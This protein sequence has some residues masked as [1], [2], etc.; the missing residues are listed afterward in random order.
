MIFWITNNLAHVVQER[1]SFDLFLYLPG[2]A[3]TLTF[4]S[5]SVRTLF[6]AMVDTYIIRLDPSALRPALKSIILALVPGL[7]DETSDDFETT[8][9]IV[10]KLQ[11]ITY[12][13]N[14]AKTDYGTPYFWQ[15]LFL[16]SIT[17]PSRRLGILAYLN[18]YL[19]KLGGPDP[20][21]S[22]PADDIDVVE[23]NYLI[24][25]VTKPDPGLL[26]RCFSTGLNDEQ[27]LVQR[28][29]LDLLVTHIP[30]HSPLLQRRISS[31]DFR[32]LVAAATSVVIRRDMSLNRRLWSWFLGP[33]SPG[34]AGDRGNITSAAGSATDFGQ[35][36]YFE[37]FGLKPLVQSLQNMIWRNSM[38][39]PERAKPFRICLSLMDRWEVGS[40]IVPRVFLPTMRS[41]QQYDRSAPTRAQFD[42]VFRSASSFFDG[43][44]SSLIFSEIIGLIRID[45]SEVKPK[46]QSALDDL[47]L[48]SFIVANFKTREEEMLL[49]H[50]PLLLLVTIAKMRTMAVSEETEP[51]L[52]GLQQAA[53]RE[54]TSLA[55][56]LLD[57][58]LPRALKKNTR[59]G[60]TE[61]IKAPSNETITNKILEFYKISRQRLELPAVPFAGSEI[62][63]M[64]LQG[65]KDLVLCTLNMGTRAS[66]LK[67]WT[68]FFTV[69]LTKA[70][71]CHSLREGGFFESLYASL[72]SISKSSKSLS[73]V[74][75]SSITLMITTLYSIHTPGSYINYKKLCAIIPFLVQ[76]LWGFMS[77]LRPKFHVEAV[78]CLW[79][80]HSVT[81]Q[82]HFVEADITSLMIKSDRAGLSHC[83]TADQAERFFILWN[84]SLQSNNDFFAS[85]LISDRPRKDGDLKDSRF[86]Y[87]QALLERPLYLVLD[88]LSDPDSEASFAVREWLK[89]PPF[90][91]RCVSLGKG[92]LV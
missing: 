22:E 8:L 59:P 30:L 80:L 69:M 60:A 52:V 41:V 28:N 86:T 36:Q 3:P 57:Q 73:F 66:F 42:E 7:E 84:H 14:D 87:Q 33:E 16:A 10:H 13:T 53:L 65:A 1:L 39:P 32:I 70:P 51:E 19:P 12:G 49:V 74:I 91:H 4:A 75:I 79:L 64:L 55:N 68:N 17:N 9:L 92:Y 54:T 15:C 29:F 82:D 71:E 81:W 45:K 11:K 47:R 34:G 72:F 24:D 58:L 85:R 18:R 61:C 21:A 35:S 44:E 88:L 38:N 48:A 76:R 56:A 37:K 83:T 89:D 2:I 78:R 90:L 50:I 43:V 77:P 25:S 23:V 5:L 31:H 46:S 40:H 20:W 63:N 67:S 6:L 26:V 27:V 62:A